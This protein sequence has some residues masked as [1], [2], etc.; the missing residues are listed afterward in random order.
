MTFL[1]TVEGKELQTVE[2]SRHRLP[3]AFVCPMGPPGPP[4]YRRQ[5]MSPVEH[6]TRWNIWRK[7]RKRGSRS[8][9]NANSGRL[10]PARQIRFQ[11]CWY[12]GVR[13]GR[14]FEED[15]CIRSFEGL[16]R[17]HVGKRIGSHKRPLAIDIMHRIVFLASPL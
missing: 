13:V 1:H 9:T 6:K 15:S 8:V 2:Y 16:S 17:W 7:L 3:R 5:E 4:W 12:H 10:S 14:D 11:P